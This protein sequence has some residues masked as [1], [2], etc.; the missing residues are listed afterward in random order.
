[1]AAGFKTAAIFSHLLPSFLSPLSKHQHLICKNRFTGISS[2][3]SVSTPETLLSL[4]FLLLLL[5]FPFL[6]LVFPLRPFCS[7]KRK[8]LKH[9]S[10]PL[11]TTGV[12]VFMF[13][14][15]HDNCFLLYFRSSCLVARPWQLP[16]H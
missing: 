7:G 11:T 5:F 10:E 13:P 3:S 2:T 16:L 1:M 4:C 15:C 12:S 8:K 9:T 14:G 6:Q